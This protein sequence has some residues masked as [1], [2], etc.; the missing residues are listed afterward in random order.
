MSCRR[1]VAGLTG[2]LRQLPLPATRAAIGVQNPCL[3][4]TSHNQR[5]PR[6]LRRFPAWDICSAMPASPPSTTTQLQGDALKAAGCYR[7]FIET[8]SGVRTDRPTLE[9]LLDQLR[10]GDTLVVW[11]LDRLGRSLRHL[12]DT[13]TGLTGRGIGFRS[14]PGGD[15]HPPGRQARLPRVRGP[16]RVRTRPA[17]R[18]HQ[19]WI[20]RRPGP[21]P[22]RRAALGHDRPHAPGG[23]GDV[24]VQAVQRGRHR[25]DSWGQ[26]GLDLPP[27][28]P[29][30]S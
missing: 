12:V 10:P 17:P 13:V 30:G 27:P 25:C 2:W 20:S 3:K 24:R 21:R 7:V 1:I 23:P 8:A 6:I 19:C 18:T 9:Q 15:R 5:C 4:S 14:L 28:D 11:K 22:P 16:G 29:P 26:P